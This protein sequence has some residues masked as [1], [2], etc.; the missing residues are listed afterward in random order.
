MADYK[1]INITLFLVINANMAR[2]QPGN[3]NAIV[4]I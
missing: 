2:S 4:R 1:I 3:V